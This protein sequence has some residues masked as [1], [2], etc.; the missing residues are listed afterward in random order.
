[1]EKR[2]FP[3][4]GAGLEVIYLIG[5]DGGSSGEI[6]DF[7]RDGLFVA[8][9]DPSQ[10]RE[11]QARNLEAGTVVD[12]LLSLPAGQVTLEAELVHL[13][14]SGIG[15][16]FF[17]NKVRSHQLLEQARQASQQTDRELANQF[18]GSNR[19]Q[20][21]NRKMRILQ[22]C[23]DQLKEYI[24]EVLPEFLNQLD[25]I[26]LK[27]AD[28][29]KNDAAQH[30]FF[31]AIAH[32]K[33]HRKS[34]PETVIGTLVSD[35]LDIVR[36]RYKPAA[37]TLAGDRNEQPL[38]LVDKG[39]FEEWLIVRVVVSRADLQFRDSLIE[40]QLRVDAA[41][42]KEGAERL[43]NP[44]SPAAITQAFHVAIRAFRLT[45][46]VERV[47]FKVFQDVVLNN[48]AR[49]YKSINNVFIRN[50][51]LPDIDVTRYL[52]AQALK[53]HRTQQPKSQ[54]EK[55]ATQAVPDVPSSKQT[56][57]ANG[58]SKSQIALDS[59][60]PAP[61]N[62][63]T[64]R[65]SQG[66]IAG[67]Y[68]ALQEGLQRARNAYSAASRLM[69]VHRGLEQQAGD[70]IRNPVAE[71]YEPNQQVV[72]VLQSAQQR[73][74][75]D[76]VNLSQPGALAQYISSVA[77]ES[78]E[79]LTDQEI[80]SAEMVESLFTNIVEHQRILAELKPELRKLEVPILRV[81]L[82]D[83]RLFSVEYHPARQFVN[84][85]SLLADRES[86]NIQANRKTV[87][88]SIQSV[89]EHHGD[90]DEG[91]V[92]A[93]ANLEQ[94]VEREKKIIE[95]NVAR[96]TQACEGQ[97]RI[98][99]ANDRIERELVNRLQNGQLPKVMVELLASG[100]RELMRLCYLREGPESRAWEMTLVVLDQ[101][102]I[103]LIPAL[104]DESKLLF[105]AEEL[106]KLIQKGL[107]KVPD[108]KGQSAA[109]SQQL[110]AR[111]AQ[112]TMTP[113]EMVD[114]SPLRDALI[115]DAAPDDGEDKSLKRWIGR[116]RKLRE[117]QWLEFDALS[118]TTHLYQLAWV[119]EQ[120]A[121][122]VFVNHHGMKMADLSLEQVAL[123]LKAGEIVV[124]SDT[125][126]PAVENGLDSLV[127]KI[128][129]KLSFESAHDQLTGMKTRKEF[130]RCL[131]QSVARAKK[132]RQQYVLIYVDILQFKVINNTCGYEAGDNLL[133]EIGQRFRS[134][135]TSEMVSGRVG[136]NEFAVIASVESEQKGFQLATEIKSALEEKRF[137]V[138]N[139]SF[140]IESV[141][142][143]VGFNQDNDQ[144]LELLRAV[145]SAAFI[146]KKSGH[147]EIQVVRPGD[148]RIEERDEVMAW[149]AR[150]NRALDFNTLKLRCQKIAPAEDEASIL[151]HFEVL[152]TVV[153]D[154]GEHLPPAEFIK[155]AEEYSRM[156]SV[157]RWVIETVLRWM[158]ENKASLDKIGGFSINLS[159]HSMNDDS[160]LD[161][162]FESLVRYEV[163]RNKLIFEVTE[164]TAVA[165]LEDAADFISEMRG[166][167]CR[168]SLD[169]F[170]AGQ[171][172]YAYLKRLPVDFIKIDGAFVKNIASDDVDYALVKSI[173][174]MGHFLN[175]KI[176]AEYV[177]DS[178]IL[179]VVR[180]IGVDYVQGYFL[181]KPVFIED[182][183]LR[184]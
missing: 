80:E 88:N 118:S 50:N 159:G 153:D 24:S 19:V 148:A 43:V 47:V 180:D 173:T 154:K 3:R 95:R 177:S 117:G 69:R 127:Q 152:L 37:Q 11:L 1:M 65:A 27:D 110:D 22:A 105:K 124:L 165:N 176:I 167:G 94:L 172:S 143:L 48:L 161:F 156:A 16:S 115:E 31:D 98:Q 125:V 56:T 29:Q 71:D 97:Q 137:V 17:G 135:I 57:A 107:S 9:S 86:V 35:A 157:D 184:H 20:D 54:P 168:F 26:L 155:A 83:P 30:P 169:D 163:P 74:V 114:Y 58:N 120:Q 149:V 179:E 129:D 160:F 150:I 62:D 78:Q 99:L 85:V 6:K 59:E 70:Q 87:I 141:V 103:R 136:S 171:S 25:D 5:D 108:N 166:I 44:Y 67:S 146:A 33:R 178:E 41:F 162:M 18:V 15:L 144:V 75:N 126:L 60:S 39:D 91:F 145:E 2:K 113:P 23:N 151:P 112:E 116:A 101:L 140:V 100:W 158:M 181:G 45:A 147:K 38:S 96:V 93:V 32:F 61:L 46:Q 90:D 8:Y 63:A 84:Y 142:S 34:L 66:A 52:A 12:L 40:L 77:G 36:G 14:E 21:E 64:L 131:A 183:Q 72:Q 170:G 122:F 55:P 79:Q 81:L 133:R 53:K 128:Y 130:E 51:V 121:R 89:L 73:L 134:V 109:I 106:Q 104:Y 28:R 10:Y 111:L 68:Q 76:S 49:L 174:E 123:K 139:Q 164:T 92:Q 4:Q 42:G 119:A 182:L 132:H 82:Q 175:K 102:L 7:S 13:N 138:N